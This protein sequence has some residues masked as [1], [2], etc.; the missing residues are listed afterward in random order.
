MPPR[1][2]A[3]LRAIN[4]GGHTVTMAALRQHVAALGYT[5]VAT[6]IASGNLIFTAETDDACALEETIAAHLQHALG[7]P[8]ATF[9]RRPAEVAAVASAE[10]F[11]TSAVMGG[12]TRLLVAFLPAA[13]DAAAVA[14]LMTYRTDSDDF[15]VIGREV[16][17]LR[18]GRISDSTFT[19][20]LLERALGLPATMRNMTTVRALA[21]RYPIDR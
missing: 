19:G 12:E 15:A 20:A 11:P 16:Y 1:Y 7:Y 3:F 17:W 8:V 4:V 9:V 2:I 6:Y 18:H 13:P 14:R 10:P 21:A 5:D